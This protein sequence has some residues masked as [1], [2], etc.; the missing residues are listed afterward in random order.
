MTDPAEPGHDT[1]RDLIPQDPEA[2]LSDFAILDG[3]ERPVMLVGWTRHAI[4][5]ITVHDLATGERLG[6]VP[7]PGLGTIGGISER[8][9][10]GHEA[11]FGYTD[12]TNPPSIQHYDARTGET[13]LWA[14]LARRGGGAAGAHRAGRLPVEGRHR[15][16]H[17][18]HLAGS[19]ARARARRSCTATAASACR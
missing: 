8:P 13:T 12:N 17:A 16:P 4:S 14:R 18:G 10:G 1:W 7:T 19:T 11:W 2:V 15:G 3:L 5:E 6:E 9:E